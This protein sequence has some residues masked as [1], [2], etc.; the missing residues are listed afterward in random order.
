M[1]HYQQIAGV[2]D[3]PQAAEHARAGLVQAGID[4][5]RIA[6]SS[7]TLDDAIAGENPGHTYENQPG[8]PRADSAAARYGAAVRSGSC[9]LTVDTESAGEGRRIGELL[10]E[11]GA[12]EI[13]SPPH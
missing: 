13:T 4:A 3:T 8:Q 11:G 7:A 5:R 9:V 1:S 6:I 12:R 2:F 10:R